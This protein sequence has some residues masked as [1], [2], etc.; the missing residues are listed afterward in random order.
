MRN[1]LPPVRFTC[2]VMGN[3]KYGEHCLGH[4]AYF[5]LYTGGTSSLEQTPV[6]LAAY[7][8]R[9]VYINFFLLSKETILFVLLNDYTRQCSQLFVR[10]WYQKGW[11]VLQW[12][13]KWL[14][15]IKRFCLAAKKNILIFQ[16][17]NNYLAA[18][19]WHTH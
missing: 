6:P 11:S 4:K 7:S 16:G 1:D 15:S 8:S 18:K 10:V 2:G 5:A 13:K 12:G 19:K 14:Y 17:L 9:T 3:M